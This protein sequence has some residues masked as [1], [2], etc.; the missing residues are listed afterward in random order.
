MICLIQTLIEF[1]L[2]Y[3]QMHK[4]LSFMFPVCT[5]T[6]HTKNQNSKNVGLALLYDI[7]PTKLLLLSPVHIG[8]ARGHSLIF[9]NHVGI[10]RKS[11]P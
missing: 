5:L 1:Q 3:E 6:F 4:I 10:K 11:R 7:K 2:D 9:Q 8:P